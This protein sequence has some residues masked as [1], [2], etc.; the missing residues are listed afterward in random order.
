[1]QDA[2]SRALPRWERI[3]RADDV[4]AYVRRMVV[5]ANVS[6]WRKFRRKET[7]TAFDVDRVAPTG[8]PAEDRDA[9]WRACQAL[10]PTSGP[11][12]CSASTKT[13]TTPRSPS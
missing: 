1:M 10:P 2:L 13:S 8:L 6:R 5:N 7:P 11:P 4:D 9:L 12:W 3:N